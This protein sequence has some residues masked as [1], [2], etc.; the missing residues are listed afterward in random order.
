MSFTPPSPQLLESIVD[1]DT[2]A[3][4]RLLDTVLPTLISWCAR[5]G[6]PSVDSEDAAHDICLVAYD[7]LH[8]LRDPVAFPAW[9]YGI[10]RRV[11]VKHRRKARW[12][13]WLPLSDVRTQSVSPTTDDVGGAA[14]AVLDRLPDDQREVL[15]LCA[16]EERTT[17]EAAELIGIAQG[18]VKS[19]LRLAR[20]RF[21][22]EARTRGVLDDLAA[23]AP[24]AR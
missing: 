5:M 18:T 19:R 20:A 2:A 23:Y 15:V 16:L 4:G 14:F 9:L 10:T 21:V 6:G 1:G 7:R 8:T 24:E 11:L 13:S 22:R 17:A 3:W 12:S